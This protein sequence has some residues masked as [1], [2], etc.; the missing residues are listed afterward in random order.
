MF[1]SGKR[2]GDNHLQICVSD[3][4]CQSEALYETHKSSTLS[5]N[6]FPISPK[7]LDLSTVSGRAYVYFIACH[8][9]F[10]ATDEVLKK[11]S[12]RYQSIDESD[13]DVGEE[14]GINSGHD[15]L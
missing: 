4:S 14:R 2:G 1:Q 12:D 15:I 13:E 8:E 5:S 6:P 7:R 11:W 10:C 9:C 3:E